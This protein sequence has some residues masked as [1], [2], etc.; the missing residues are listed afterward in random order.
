[1]LIASTV[2]TANNPR[3]SLSH[4]AGGALLA[5]AR[6]GRT[7]AERALEQASQ[8]QV[9]VRIS[10]AIRVRYDRTLQPDFAV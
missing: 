4:V 6:G 7:S 10:E 2:T 1:M 9:S 5:D 3:R 8:N